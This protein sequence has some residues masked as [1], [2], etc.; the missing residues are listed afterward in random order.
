MKLS[1]A[2]IASPCAFSGK[3]GNGSG[4]Q[5]SQLQDHHDPIQQQLINVSEPDPRC[6]KEHEPLI[7]V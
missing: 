2:K 6:K 5:P 7:A 3:H 4:F 1:R